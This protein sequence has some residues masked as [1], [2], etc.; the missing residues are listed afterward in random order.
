MINT[1]M[2]FNHCITERPTVV[3]YRSR[4]WIQYL[5]CAESQQDEFD[6]YRQMSLQSKNFLNECYLFGVGCIVKA[7]GK[8]PFGLCPAHLFIIISLFF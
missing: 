3:Q 6:H 2:I 4:K 5:P 8:E 1:N 7:K